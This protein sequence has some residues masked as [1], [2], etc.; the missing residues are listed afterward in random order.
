M[1]IDD[2]RKSLKVYLISLDTAGYIKLDSDTFERK[3]F[4][5]VTTSELKY[6]V[7]SINYDK[8]HGF[9]TP[10]FL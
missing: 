8:Q 2:R 9:V 6:R 4:I 10:N 1:T 3:R 5:D 7:E